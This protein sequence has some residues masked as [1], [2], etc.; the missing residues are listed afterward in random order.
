MKDIY[1]PSLRGMK[2]RDSSSSLL[3]ACSSC[4]L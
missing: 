1:I 3:S 2:T 4:P